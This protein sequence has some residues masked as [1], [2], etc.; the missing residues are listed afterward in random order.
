MQQF[1]STMGKNIVPM[2]SSLKIWGLK[3]GNIFDALHLEEKYCIRL[4]FKI[5]L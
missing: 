5:D 1:G 4:N 3:Y 2:I